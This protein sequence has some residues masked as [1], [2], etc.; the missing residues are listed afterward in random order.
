M[1]RDRCLSQCRQ[2]ADYAGVIFEFVRFGG[3]FCSKPLAEK[4]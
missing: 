2:D 3:I 4:L 1:W